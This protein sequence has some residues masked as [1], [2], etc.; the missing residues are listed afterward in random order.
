MLSETTIIPESLSVFGIICFVIV[1]GYYLAKIV[2][3]KIELDAFGYSFIFGLAIQLVGIAIC[4]ALSFAFFI[5]FK[6]L[7]FSIALISV[8]VFRIVA[9]KV[10]VSL[11]FES[12]RIDISKSLHNPTLYIFLVAFILRFVFS[13]YNSASILPDASLY[14][15]TA[16]SLATKGVLSSNV[17]YDETFLRLT[18][19]G[20]IDHVFVVFV[21]AFFFSVS[22]ISISSALVAV[23]SLGAFLIYPLYDFSRILFG[24]GTAIIAATIVS[25]APVFLYFSSILFGPEIS[26]LLFVLTGF[27]LLID[28]GIGR[29][30]VLILLL[31]GTM[32]GISEEIWFPQFYFV[33]LFIPILITLFY[34]DN[35]ANKKTIIGSF[36]GGVLFFTYVIALKTYSL[37][38]I[39][40]PITIAEIILFFFSSRFSKDIRYY[41]SMTVGVLIAPTFTIVRHYILPSQVVGTVQKAISVGLIPSIINAF[42]TFF[43][44]SLMEGIPNYASY[45]TNYASIVIV[46]MFLLSFLITDKFKP[47]IIL[48]ALVFLNFVF[49]S[50]IPPPSYPQYLA[51]QG[52]YYLMPVAL[53]IIGGS[54]FAFEIARKALSSFHKSK[55]ILYAIAVFVFLSA[56]VACFFVPAYQTNIKEISQQN[57]ITYYGWSKSM[58]NW[59]K[60]NTTNQDVFLTDRARELAWFTNRQT[61]SIENSNLKSTNI[62]Y[63]TLASIYHQFNASYLIVDN[64]FLWT[65][66]QLKDLYYSAANPIGTL[67][68]PRDVF[69][70]SLIGGPN[71]L[72]GYK[73]VF[74]DSSTTFGIWKLESSSTLSLNSTYIDLLS[75]SWTLNQG[76]I[77]RSQNG[78]QLTI[79]EG[80]NY[81]FTHSTKPLNVVLDNQSTR[82]FVWN[83]TDIHN[84]TIARIEFWNASGDQVLT[85]LPPTQTGIWSTTI[86]VASFSDM[87]IVITGGSGSYVNIEWIAIGSYKEVSG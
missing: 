55:K 27:Y 62:D 24:R 39:Y 78:Y 69:L 3:T 20:L 45:I 25:V 83:I 26:S 58:L 23:V 82:M 60:A 59:I 48:A 38:F 35:F 44:G 12:L 61:V 32:I 74:S 72:Q 34:S 73:L 8:V 85:L 63:A 86:N 19:S 5:N 22:N 13:T 65:F 80:N 4:S 54:F 75:D 47:K 37:Y 81:A 67:F 43:K 50:M 79:G 68:L 1:S 10:G 9:H 29:R 15:D 14:L 53:M 18:T 7:L 36:V 42:T 76:N 6:V 49:V 52:R 84:A 66:P 46:L 40:I 87:R 56:I 57:P 28:N 51:S 16:R 71:S 33:V 2:S 70:S 21:F 31:A 17:I 41:L 64:Y 77:S 11:N 30:S